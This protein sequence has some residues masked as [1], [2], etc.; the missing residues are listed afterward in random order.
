MA[1][2]TDPDLCCTSGFSRSSLQRSLP[3]LIFNLCF[4]VVKVV[5][6]ENPISGIIITVALL[7]GDQYVGFWA[8]MGTLISTFTALLLS[9]SVRKGSCLTSQDYLMQ[10]H[11]KDYTDLMD[12]W[13]VLELLY[14]R[15]GIGMSPRKL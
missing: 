6:I 7:L 3:G 12:A 4:L 14:L 5:F 1:R 2:E 10:I 8:F 11:N 15:I 9:M 13:L